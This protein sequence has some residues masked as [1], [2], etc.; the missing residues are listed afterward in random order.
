VVRDFFPLF[1]FACSN[2]FDPGAHAV[3]VAPHSNPQVLNL[4]IR[5]S[6]PN[7][8]RN[9]DSANALIEQRGKRFPAKLIKQ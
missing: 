1:A 2:L 5:L 8:Q 7:S 9:S 4:R 6:V 3:E